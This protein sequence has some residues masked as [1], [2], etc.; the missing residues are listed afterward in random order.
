VTEGFAFDVHARCGRARAGVVTTPR[1][2]VPTPAFMPVGTVGAVK[3]ADPDEVR[4]SGAS[5]LLGNAYHLMLRP[6]EEL[7]R[8]AGGLAAF[9]GWAGRP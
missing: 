3:S 5:I 9:M 1:G 2:A 6:G 4:A 8:R 7:I